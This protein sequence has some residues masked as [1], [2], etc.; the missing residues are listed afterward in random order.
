MK[1]FANIFILILGLN[2]PV[3]AQTY[4]LVWQEDFDGNSLDSSVWNVVER[5][6]IWNT[7][8]NA[9]LEFYKTENVSVGDDGL[10]NNCLIISTLKENVNGYSFSSGRINSNAKFSFKYGKLVAKIKIPDLKNGLWPAF[11]TEGFTPIGWPDMGEIDILEMGHKDAITADTVNFWLSS[12]TH[13][14]NNN[15]RADH[16]TKILTAENLSE[17]YHTYTLEWTPTS[18]KTYLDSTRLIFSFTISGTDMEEYKDYMHFIL[19]NMAVGGSLTGITNPN[20]ITAP[21]PAKMYV[22]YIK[23]YQLEGS[24]NFDTIPHALSGKFGVYSESDLPGGMNDKFDSEILA[25]GLDATNTGIYEGFKT[26]A[27]NT[28]ASTDFSLGVKSYTRRDMRN[29]DQGGITFAIKTGYTGDLTISVTDTNNV[30]MSTVLN[31]GKYYDPDRNNTWNLITVPVSDFTGSIDLSAVKE[32]FAIS[33]AADANSVLLAIDNIVWDDTYSGGPVT[34]QYYGVYA[35]HPDI[36]KK[37]DFGSTGHLYVWNGFTAS[38]TTPVYGKT[39]I[40]FNANT[41][42][43]N[44]LGLQ[45]DDIIN[46][47]DF[48]NGRMNLFIKTSSSAEFVFG[49]KN[50]KGQSWEK[51]YAAGETTSA[52]KRDGKWH[53]LNLPMSDFKPVSGSPALTA[54]GLEDVNIPFYLVGTVNIGLDEIYF[55]KDN[56]TIDYGIFPT[57]VENTINPEITIYPVPSDGILTINGLQGKAEVGIYDLTGKYLTAISMDNEGVIDLS[58]YPAGIYI[59]HIKTNNESLRKIFVIE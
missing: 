3:L 9:E 17:D 50:L 35:D 58:S 49:F 31:S 51:K 27:Y 8:Q 16:S 15:T 11:W 48:I 29:Y 22:D 6:G 30:S 10:G 18:I 25:T 40:S 54:K 57:A 1:F 42:T 32:L 34:E 12:A 46:L 53:L 44:G 23:L 20:N 41:G 52:F 28:Q 56:T 26:L 19:I 21:F 45:L 38:A 5:R 36:I 47:S 37:L 13:W 43:W 4:H 55:S 33:G 14:E 39:V 2:S 59:M 7:G 24:E